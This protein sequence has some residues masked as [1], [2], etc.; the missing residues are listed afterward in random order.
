MNRFIP[1][2]A[3]LSSGVQGGAFGARSRDLR[4]IQ[5]PFSAITQSHL[6]PQGGISI[7]MPLQMFVQ[8]PPH[9]YPPPSHPRRDDWSVSAGASAVQN[10]EQTESNMFS[11]QQSQD[12]IYMQQ[13]GGM[14]GKT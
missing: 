10:R 6:H 9:Y 4:T 11:S 13:I 14:S 3:I 12:P 2:G 5:D 8:P 7:P 1:R